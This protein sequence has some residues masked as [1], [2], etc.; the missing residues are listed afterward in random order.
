MTNV[1]CS[2]AGAGISGV[3]PWPVKANGLLAALHGRAAG[4]GS[5]SHG[6]VVGN[7]V[8]VCITIKVIFLRALGRGLRAARARRRGMARLLGW[9]RRAAASLVVRGKGR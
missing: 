1:G 9:R 2:L 6:R 4:V 5:P 7:G 3:V 8:G